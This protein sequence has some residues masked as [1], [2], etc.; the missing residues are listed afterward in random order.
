VGFGLLNA[1]V[2]GMLPLLIARSMLSCA[3]TIYWLLVSEILLTCAAAGL[4]S[5]WS[6]Q[7]AF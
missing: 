4:A 5:S 6:W 1:L 3:S 2:F 7:Q